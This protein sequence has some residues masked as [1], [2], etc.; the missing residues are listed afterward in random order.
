MK[1]NYDFAGAAA[2]ITGAASGMGLPPPR[3][4]VKPGPRSLYATRRRYSPSKSVCLRK[5]LSRRS[6]IRM[7]DRILPMICPPKRAVSSDEASNAII[8]TLEP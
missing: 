6:A 5:R 2:L 4:L 1:V 8:V 3:P 7:I